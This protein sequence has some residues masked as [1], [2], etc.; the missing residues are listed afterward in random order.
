M[1]DTVNTPDAVAG[2]TSA[3]AFGALS[4]LLCWWFPFGALLGATGVAVGLVSG[5]ADW[6]RGRAVFGGLLAAGGL[7]AALVM[8]WGSWVRWLGW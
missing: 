2:G 6:G 4:L 7:G 3:L 8:N 1:A 5:L